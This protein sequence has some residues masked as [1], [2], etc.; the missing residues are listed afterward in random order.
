[1][2]GKWG[3]CWYCEIIISFLEVV[4]PR[5]THQTPSCITFAIDMF[6]EWPIGNLLKHGQ[7]GCLL[8]SVLPQ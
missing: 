4:G 8:G 7:V 3:N 6:V 2:V 1:M 5:P